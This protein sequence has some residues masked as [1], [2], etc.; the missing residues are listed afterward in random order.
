MTEKLVEE[1]NRIPKEKVE[2]WLTDVLNRPVNLDLKSYVRFLEM[3]NELDVRYADTKQL[4]GFLERFAEKFHLT[5]HDV[6][7]AD[8]DVTQTITTNLQA[9][10]KKREQAEAQGKD[11]SLIDRVIAKHQAVLANHKMGKKVAEGNSGNPS[12]DALKNEFANYDYWYEQSDDHRY[13]RAGVA[14]DKRITALI[15]QLGL[16]KEDVMRMW[17][18][19]GRKEDIPLARFGLAPKKV[20]HVGKPPTYEGFADPSGLWSAAKSNAG[21]MKKFRVFYTDP[22]TPG[23]K[24]KI[25]KVRADGKEDDVV[26]HFKKKYPEFKINYVEM[27]G[28]VGEGKEVTGPRAKRIF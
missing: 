12:I 10:V 27:I 23:Y 15:Q 24:T 5:G 13:W 9:L 26:I 6:Y 3:Y 11:T 20:Y 1:Y 25:F 4:Q 8:P 21:R 2:Q 16:S 7:E 19:A 28:Y 17:A 18:E 22:S 14:S